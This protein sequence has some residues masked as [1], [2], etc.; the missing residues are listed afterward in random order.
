MAGHEIVIERAVF[1]TATCICGWRSHQE[2]ETEIGAQR[3]G[4]FHIEHPVLTG[5]VP[6]IEETQQ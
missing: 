2:W 3:D 4:D 5:E 6:A 1:F